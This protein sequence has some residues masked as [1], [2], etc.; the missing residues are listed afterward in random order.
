MRLKIWRF[1]HGMLLQCRK[2]QQKNHHSNVQ[3][4]GACRNMVNTVT[5]GE[6]HIFHA[7]KG[8]KSSR[9]K[10]KRYH[11]LLSGF[12]LKADPLT[13]TISTRFSSKDLGSF[14]QTLNGPYTLRPALVY[15]SS[16]MPCYPIGWGLN[17][18]P[19]DQL[20]HAVE[21]QSQWNSVS[22]FLHAFVQSSKCW[23]CKTLW[24]ASCKLISHSKWHLSGISLG[25]HKYT[26][27]HGLFAASLTLLLAKSQSLHVEAYA[28]KIG[29]APKK[30]QPLALQ[31]THRGGTDLWIDSFPSKKAWIISWPHPLFC[32]I[33]PATLRGRLC[34]CE[35]GFGSG[36]R[37]ACCCS[38]QALQRV[39][40]V[41]LAS[42]IQVYQ[43]FV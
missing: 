25:R 2:I 23:Y 39:G 5:H 34:P 33:W 38:H 16:W 37:S 40:C 14:H 30:L 19:V 36:T 6:L 18:W 7:C 32:S 31:S 41:D 29:D 17:G 10:M 43:S 22:S 1:Y 24:K 4:G 26:E 9:V 3:S 8:N 20:A 35:V 12:A 21:T 15:L 27:S 42:R 13:P 11:W 28:T